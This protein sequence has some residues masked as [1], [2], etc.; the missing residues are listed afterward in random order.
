MTVGGHPVKEGQHK[1]LPYLAWI[2]PGAIA[3]IVCITA[4]VAALQTVGNGLWFYLAITVS[5]LAFG[6]ALLTR[7]AISAACKTAGEK[8]GDL[9]KAEAEWLRPLFDALARIWLLRGP[10]G[11]PEAPIARAVESL[12]TGIG[13]GEIAAFLT[14]QRGKGLRLVA[15][16]SRS[17][18]GSEI[19]VPDLAMSMA[20]RAFHLRRLIESDAFPHLRQH[21]IHTHTQAT[22]ISAL[23]LPL[24]SKGRIWGVLFVASEP[25][26]SLSGDQRDVVRAFA[27]I[28]AMTLDATSLYGEVR[29]GRDQMTTLFKITRDITSHLQLEELLGSIVRRTVILLGGFCGGVR[30]VERTES[31]WQYGAITFWPVDEND[32]DLLPALESEMKSVVEHGRPKVVEI[33]LQP[34]KVSGGAEGGN[35]TAGIIVPIKWEGEVTGVLYVLMDRQGRPFPEM[36]ASLL[37]LLASQAAIAV[38]NSR[39]YESCQALAVTDPLTGLYNRRFFSAELAR[40]MSRSTRE[41]KPLSL[42]VLDVDFLKRHNDAKGHLEGDRVLCQIAE[43]MSLVVRKGDI[44]SRYGG[45]EFAVLLPGATERE[46]LQVAERIRSEVESRQLAGA[47]LSVSLGLATFPTDADDGEKLMLMADRR[48]YAAKAQGRNRVCGSKVDPLR[49]ES[50]VPPI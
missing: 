27:D 28:L 48:L 25:G 21:P 12:A 47:D 50:V 49:Q 23:A 18:T 40:E 8:E 43:I 14:D 46:A 44:A 45:D 33:P 20:Q 41:G 36:D 5:C 9:H 4:L 10:L 34:P 31:G 39:L 2:V 30:L 17:P 11:D 26:C 3:L 19:R 29:R 22:S 42:I 37:N 13:L 32:D 15:H 35:N 38:E 1:G 16:Y 6:A 7:S 24:G